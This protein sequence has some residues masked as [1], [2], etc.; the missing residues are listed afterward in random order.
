MTMKMDLQ[1]TDLSGIAHTF[2]EQGFVVLRGFLS[3]PTIAALVQEA[4]GLQSDSKNLIARNNLRC[5]YRAHHV[6][7]ELLFECFDPV[8]DIAPRIKD[9]AMCDP[10]RKVLQA[11]YGGPGCLFKDKLIFKPPGALGYP[12]HQDFMAWTG[13]PKSFLTVVIPLDAATEENGCVVVYSGH[14]RSGL[15]TPADGQF[16]AVPRSSVREADR[17]PLVLDPGDIAIFDGFTPHESQPNGSS[18]AR[19]QIYLSYN[20]RADGGDCRESHY[21]QFHAWIQAKYPRPADTPWFFA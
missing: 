15:M 11:I 9:T 18:H 2:Y 13:F 1:R 6:S 4:V 12:L 7:G 10:L 5:R 17:V 16:H 20:S 19:R 3:Q 14:H 8:V 21:A